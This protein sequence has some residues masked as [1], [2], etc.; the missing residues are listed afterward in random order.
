[1]PKPRKLPPVPK[2]FHSRAVRR[3]HK[4]L[5]QD[6]RRLRLVGGSVRDWL[7]RRPIG[8][9]DFAIDAPPDAVLRLLQQAGIR[10]IP[11]GIDHGTV[12]AVMDGKNF[13][14]TSLRQD[15]TTDGRRAVVRFGTDWT[16]DAARRDFTINALYYELAEGIFDPLLGMGDIRARR[17]RFIG[18]AR[19][20]IREDFLRSL[21][22]FR[23]CAQL[24]I[25]P[26]QADLAA[27]RAE[28]AGLRG[29]SAERVRQELQKL[30]SAQNPIPALRA[31]QKIGV[32]AKILPRANNVAALARLLRLNSGADWLLR[33]AVLHGGA[34]TSYRP[35]AQAVKRLALS[36]RQTDYVYAVASPSP[37]SALSWRQALYAQGAEIFLARAQYGCALKILTAPQYRRA[38]QAAKKWRPKKFP[39]RGQ[40]LL[41]VGLAPGP[42]IGR[43]LEITESW[44]IKNKF[45]PNK[46][47]CLA[48][49]L[50][51]EPAHLP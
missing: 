50:S 37:E 4:I 26:H 8:D 35:L 5:A 13:E 11:T 28:L 43:M 42:E 17:L 49:A 9:L 19:Q 24:D 7:L 25:R 32:L 36:N 29:L 22:L 46:R 6:G 47:L 40:D 21:R 20:R 15:I 2:I 39:L 41:D 12:T 45:K 3:L 38:V 1:M 51:L 30:L 48:F 34:K 27:V 44:W 14:I 10:A 33:F 23:F 31:M 18:D 16:A